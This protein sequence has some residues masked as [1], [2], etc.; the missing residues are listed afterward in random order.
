MADLKT[1]VLEVNTGGAITN[2]KEFKAYL[3]ELKGTLLGLEKGTDDYKK[4]A[5]EL[6]AGQQKLNEVM[7][8]AKGRGDAL[9]GSY[10]NLTSTMA[11][12]KREWKATND[13]AER[14]SLGK[15]INAI[16]D[17]LK[18]LDASIGN[19]QRN[20]GNYAGAFEEA[21]KNIA[22]RAGSNG[23]FVGVL[24]KNVKGLI[25]LIKQVN[26]TAISGLSGIKKAIA[27]TGIGLLVV[28]LGEVIA[29]LDDITGAL[30]R[31]FTKE[32]SIEEEAKKCNEQFEAWQK[33]IDKMDENNRLEK[34]RMELEGISQV[35]IAQTVLENAKNALNAEANVVAALLKDM[36]GAA[37]KLNDEYRNL[38]EG[39]L[40]ELGFSQEQINLLTKDFN[41]TLGDIGYSQEEIEK[42]QQNFIFYIQQTDKEQSK[43]VK[44]DAFKKMAENL[45]LALTN[46]E[47]YMSQVKSLG[48]SEKEA[49]I[50]EADRAKKIA[51]RAQ[52]AFMSTSQL[53]TKTYKKEK[54]L[55][56]K[57]FGEGSA[58]VT[59]LTREYHKK[60]RDIAEASKL[61]DVIFTTSNKEFDK[62]KTELDKFYVDLKKETK[63]VA[64]ENYNTNMEAL[65][66]QL[67]EGKLS[68][69]EYLKGVNELN[70]QYVEQSSGERLKINQEVLRMEYEQR[71]EYLTKGEADEVAQIDKTANKRKD[72]L[73]KLLRD[74]KIS[75]AEYNKQVT[76]LDNQTATEKE[77]IHQRYDNTRLRL[78][79]MYIQQ[80]QQ[81]EVTSAAETAEKKLKAIEGVYKNKKVN[82]ELGFDMEELNLNQMFDKKKTNPFSTA[83]I[84]AYFD[85]TTRRIEELHTNTQ[86]MLSEQAAALQEQIS[87]LPEGSE[88][89]LALEQQL[90]NTQVQIEQDKVARLQE[91]DAAN[92]DYQNQLTE[93]Q[94]ERVEYLKQVVGGI[95][96]LMGN[97][98]SFQEEM[99]KEDIANGKISEEEG[100]KQYERVKKLQVAQ[101][102]INTLSG[103]IGAYMQAVKTYP[104]PW[105]PILG[106]ITAASVTAA[107]AA[108]IKK[109][110]SS[111]LSSSSVSSPGTQDLSG[112]VNEYNPTYTQNVTSQTEISEL[113]NA[114]KSTPIYVSVTDIDSTQNMVRTREQETSW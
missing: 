31:M 62:I 14:A 79:Q 43:L 46:L 2:L 12:L 56:V 15:Q 87:Q 20:V 110:K 85:L 10:D 109:I 45:K 27:A 5:D 23:N 72:E 107:G 55:L 60:L 44:N 18:S 69:E 80:N 93:R 6:R 22:Q 94:A 89:R 114:L 3:D 106:G 21:F 96:D 84:E 51:E 77:K 75:Q 63:L 81:L 25:P 49:E 78:D 26:T 47:K 4:T 100:K 86:G 52:E 32:V 101:A 112:I 34:L 11:R 65:R 71:K 53:I 92:E 103:A 16:N 67:D 70:L 83:D 28:A 29:H 38:N 1:A 113:A 73:K 57:Q 59:A 108:Q 64:T 105:G 82:V 99:I 30:G 9:E 98:A 91:I 8:I 39:T 111:S 58:E 19:Y 42:H 35:D 102:V 68:F 97:Y 24:A 74:S 95:G 41:K 76:E 61:S 88:E 33:E 48:T 66:K 90:A 40:K 37:R 104:A 7:D 36:R 13:E 17:Q 50:R 54:E